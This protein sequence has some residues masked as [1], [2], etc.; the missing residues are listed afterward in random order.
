MPPLKKKFVTA[1]SPKIF[2]M[3]MKTT[4]KALKEDSIYNPYNPSF[5]ALER[6]NA[7]NEQ[8]AR[9]TRSIKVDVGN[10]VTISVKDVV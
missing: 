1:L 5:R 7:K 10:E 6:V 4:Q 8:N 9:K 2:E 3:I